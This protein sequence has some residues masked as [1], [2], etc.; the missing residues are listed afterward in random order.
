MS[1]GADTFEDCDHPT[2]VAPLTRC[3]QQAEG[4]PSAVTG[5]VDFAAPHDGDNESGASLTP[6]PLDGYGI[7]RLAITFI[8]AA[9]IQAAP[10]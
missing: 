6:D 2:G 5:R 1:R 9:R 4:A 3:V 10:A 8:S 7:R